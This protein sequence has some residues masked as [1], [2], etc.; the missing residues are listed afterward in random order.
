VKYKYS[1]S[2][3]G[4]LWNHMCQLRTL[5]ERLLF[6]VVGFALFAYER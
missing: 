5:I 3:K 6:M 2:V 4:S 1:M